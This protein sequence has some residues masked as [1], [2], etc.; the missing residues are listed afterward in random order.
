MYV[1]FSTFMQLADEA[2]EEICGIVLKDRILLVKNIAADRRF[3]AEFSIESMI[4]MD[5]NQ[6]DIT[7]LIHSHLGPAIMSDQDKLSQRLYGYDFYIYSKSEGKL[8]WFPLTK[9]QKKN[10]RS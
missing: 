6:R 3:T 1:D 4:F 10:A 8:E 7:A 2:D 5:N 9:L